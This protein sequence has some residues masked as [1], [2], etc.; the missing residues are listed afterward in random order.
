[1]PLARRCTLFLSLAVLIC[2]A[3]GALQAAAPGAEAAVKQTLTRYYDAFGR[4]DAKTYRTLVTPDYVLL[5]NGEV[6]D[7]EADIAGMPSGPQTPTRKDTLAFRSV[8]VS[9]DVAYAVYVLTAEI[10]DA[11]GTQRRRWLES[12]VLR[13]TGTAWRIAVLHSTSIRTP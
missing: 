8:R 1:M 6:M 13:R 5:E 3:T 10:T 4:L 11:S 12:A 2:T 9:G 7:L